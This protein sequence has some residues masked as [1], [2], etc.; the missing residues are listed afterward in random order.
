MDYNSNRKKL[1][2]PEY[3]RN[4]QSMVDQVVA[5]KD[6][7]ER[8]AAAQRTIEIMG[9]LFPYLRDV[10]DFKHKLWD[11]IAIMSDFELDIDSP[12]DPPKREELSTKPDKMA[13]PQG[14]IRTRHYGKVLEEI[15]S[16][17]VKMEDGELRTKLVEL[18]ANYMKK[19]YLVWNND[20]VDDAQIIKDLKSIF[21]GKIDIDKDL[22][23]I[24]TK[25]LLSRARK[26]IPEA[27][28]RRTGG[29]GG[30]QNR[31]YGTQNRSQGGQQNRNYGSPGGAQRG[32]RTNSD[33]RKG[34]QSRNPK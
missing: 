8:N 10:P 9:N 34:A 2:M 6:R 30:Q 21:R 22:A 31:S 4:I 26:V 17:A 28:S 33:N 3:G 18:I 7:E 11:H 24:D 32:A 25:E 13:Y 14:R 5:I 29:Q 12:Y 16:E 15:A 1:I 20:S 19:S 23:L 27:P